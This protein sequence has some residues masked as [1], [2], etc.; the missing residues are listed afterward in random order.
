[1]TE[2]VG[3]RVLVALAA[4]DRD[5]DRET[6]ARLGVIQRAAERHPL[7]PL[8]AG[9]VAALVGDRAPA[10]KVFEL[11]EGNPLIVEELVTSHL[12]RDPLGLRARLLARLAAAEQPAADPS[13][14][15]ARAL[16]ATELAAGLAP[17]D[18]SNVLYVASAALVEYVHGEQL[19]RLHREVLA[20]ARGDGWITTHT[21]LRLC[22][23]ALDGADR[24]SFDA[25]RAAFEAEATALGLPSGSGTCMRCAR[26]W[27]CWMGVRAG[28]H[29]SG[30]KP[31][32]LDRPG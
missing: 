21:R 17:R 1:M 6:A 13:A 8:G 27:R 31:G 14:P 5:C 23:A 7:G 3:S 19:M 20:L 16:E 30:A 15:I 11:S 25:E 9:E 24:A 22:F 28:R 12:A 4:R 2:L 26:S 18:R 32:H 29:R 10:R